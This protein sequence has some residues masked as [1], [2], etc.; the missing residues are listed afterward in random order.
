MR[1]GAFARLARLP[2]KTLRFYADEGV[3]PPAHI[4]PATGYR[5]FAASQL[6]DLVKILNFREAGLGLG[7]IRKLLNA[8]DTKPLALSFTV[9]RENLLAARAEI[10]KRIRIVDALARLLD[11]GGEVALGQVRLVARD[12]ERGFA[13]RRRAAS[14]GAPVTEMFEMAEREVAKHG[15]RAPRQP[16]LQFHSP[17]TEARDIDVEVFI[18]VSDNAPEALPVTVLPGEAVVC[19][20]IY[21]GG[22][23]Q[24]APLWEKINAWLRAANLAAAGPL[25]E[26]YH[27]FGA[28][29]VGYDLPRQML[30]TRPQDYVTELQVEVALPDDAN[31]GGR[32]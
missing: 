19:S 10:E 12:A 2:V 22:Y 20:L 11:A 28:D 4:D 25:R 23:E 32:P 29:Q 1:I 30:A 7:E 21:S 18:P 27:Q 6:P 13:L 17:P 5:Y 14:L 26:I 8:E 9:H 15:A 24:T 3:L 16:L 31:E